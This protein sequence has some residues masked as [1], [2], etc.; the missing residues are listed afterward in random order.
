MD[1]SDLD[2]KEKNYINGK[3][4]QFMDAYIRQ[5]KVWTPEQMLESFIEKIEDLVKQGNFNKRYEDSTFVWSSQLADEWIISKKGRSLSFERM[6]KKYKKD[7]PVA[8]ANSPIVERVRFGFSWD[9]S[10]FFDISFGLKDGYNYIETDDLKK[11]P[12]KPWVIKHVE[13]QLDEH[14]GIDI[15]H[16]LKQLS[17]SPIEKQFY[18]YWLDNYYSDKD[19]PS[20]IPEVCGFRAK[21]YY[22]EYLGKVYATRKDIPEEAECRDVKS[23]N[24]RYDYFISNTKKKKAALIE[25]DGHEFHKTKPQRIIDSIKRN[26]AATL[27]LPVIVFTGTKLNENIDSCFASIDD[28]LSK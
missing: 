23:K 24:F 6:K 4:S 5:H 26:E 20:I 22:Y 15:P 17:T 14:Y 1:Y 16:I 13:Q 2:K 25:L 21:F 11:Y 9:K 18:K 12:F 19:N 10:K 3:I 7:K 27:G 28:I 8:R